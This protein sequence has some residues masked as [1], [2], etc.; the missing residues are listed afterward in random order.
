[1]TQWKIDTAHSE[2]NFKVKHLVVSTVTGHFSRFDALI[3]SGNNDFT[4]ACITFEADIDS[5]NTKNEQRDGHLKSPDFFDAAKYPKMSFVSASAVKLSD[6]ELRVT[7]NLTMRG[8]TRPVTL[9]VIYN[10]TV[11]G[12]GG[13]RVAGFEV[14]GK[15]N[16]FDFGLQWS[17]VTETGGVV[18]S[19]EVK[20]EIL[21]EFNM[22][23]D[24]VKAA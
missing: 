10:G 24:A 22:A 13:T 16:R 3:E 5:I 23:L 21:A 4:D 8:V 9:D 15:L 17:A 6:H 7:G 19:N 12:F 20:I 1:M 18:V 2:V 14:R 11:A